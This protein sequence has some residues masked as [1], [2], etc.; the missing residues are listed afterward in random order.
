M[1]PFEIIEQ[2]YEKD[3]PSY[4]ILVRHSCDVAN[5][6]VKIATNH[7][8]LNI[9]KTFVWEASMLHDIGIFLTNAPDIECYGTFPY[10]SH[11][12]LGHDLLIRHHLP[13]H[14]LVCE[15]HTGV[16]LSIE[17]II[18]QDLP[19][20]HR[21]MRPKSIEE[22]VVCFADCF[23]SKSNLDK[24]KSPD[25]IKKKL[26]KMGADKAEQFDSWCNLFL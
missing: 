16:G 1:D 14:A 7:P 20:P 8:E 2:Y 24:E 25:K 6:A 18:Q 21:D 22:Q 4:N 12:F 13:Q 17:D 23:F 15:R 5:K 26:D 9:D 3:S 10:I 19:L 11:G